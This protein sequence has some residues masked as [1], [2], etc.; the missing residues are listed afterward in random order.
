MADEITEIKKLLKENQLIIGK[1]ET[2][3]GLRKG[4][5]EKVFLAKIC[6]EGAKEEIEHYAAIAS[7]E[8]VVVEL[9]NSE[10]KEVCKRPHNI[11]II[12][13]KKQ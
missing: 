10:L 4:T 7:V 1:D 8:V 9:E 13:V 2:M 11:A 3:K 5:I 6:P 12:S